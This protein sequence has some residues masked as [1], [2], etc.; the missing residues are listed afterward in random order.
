[1]LVLLRV[2][3]VL[4]ATAVGTGLGFVM[5]ELLAPDMLKFLTGI[6]SLVWALHLMILPKFT[7]LSGLPGLREREHERL[8]L[9]LAEFR[10]RTWYIGAVCLLCTLAMIGLIVRFSDWSA[11]QL[12]AAV[13]MLLGVGGSYLLLVPVWTEEMHAFSEKLR[14]RDA[15]QK[16]LELATKDLGSAVRDGGAGEGAGPLKPTSSSRRN[17]RKKH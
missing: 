17:G 14:L 5:P 16:R 1:M 12:G 3:I 13:G 7:E 4:A 10:R 6:F 8:N 2:A 9:V 15:Q 11:P